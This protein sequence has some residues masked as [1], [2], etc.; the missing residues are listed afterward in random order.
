[1]HM[2]LAMGP[3]AESSEL[4]IEAMVLY[5]ATYRAAEKEAHR[6]LRGNSL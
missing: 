6:D 4:M 2:N 5:H 1:M 3:R